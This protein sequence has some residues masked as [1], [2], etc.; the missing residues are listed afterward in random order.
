MTLSPGVSMGCPASA[1]TQCHVGVQ[2]LQPIMAPSQPHQPCITCEA[3]QEGSVGARG[4]AGMPQRAQVAPVCRPPE[5]GPWSGLGCGPA[6]CVTE[7]LLEV[8][9][10]RF[11]LQTRQTLPLST[12]LVGASPPLDVLSHPPPR[13]EDGGH[14]LGTQGQGQVPFQIQHCLKSQGQPSPIMGVSVQGEPKTHRRDEQ[15]WPSL[16]SSGWASWRVN[17]DLQAP[18]EHK[19]W[20][21]SPASKASVIGTPARLPCL[22][23][24]AVWG[25]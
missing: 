15:D 11:S 8:L 5:S 6:R 7:I 16:C 22:P 10:P 14:L 21:H 1:G 20:P 23:A 19:C 13:R 2:L 9:S 12:P 17:T 4:H 24:T 3:H 25:A 18:A